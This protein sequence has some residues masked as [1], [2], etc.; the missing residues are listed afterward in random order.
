MR[1]KAFIS[2]CAGLQLTDEERNFFQEHNPWGFI[3]FARN[4]AEPEQVL[5]LT[6]DLRNCTGRADTAILIDQEGGRVQRLR[7]PHWHEYPAARLLGQLYAENPADGKRAAWLQSRLIAFE[8]ARLGI[9]VNCLP[10]LD[11]P[12]PGAHDVIGDRAYSDHPFEVEQMA[13]AACEGL[14][15]GSILPVIKHIPGHGRAFADSH[16]ALPCVDVH[17]AVLGCTDFQ[18]FM[19]LADMPIAMTAHV[20]YSALDAT[21]P[22][23]TSKTIIEKLIRGWLD[24]D[25]LLLSDDLSMHA[26]SGELDQRAQSSFAAGCDIV[27]HCNGNMDEMAK[28]AAATPLLEGDALRRARSATQRLGDADNSDEELLRAEFGELIATASR[29]SADLEGIE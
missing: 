1:I 14:L 16:E 29:S 18:P 4:I 3:L 19:Q 24:Y 20:I 2:G 15:A 27:L 26:L 8:L 17:P 5:A 11:V 6:N 13:R 23:T 10:V 21:K 22:A 12:V 25:G 9:N 7:P 28:V